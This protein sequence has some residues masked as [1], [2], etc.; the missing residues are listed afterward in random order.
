MKRK[1]LK[2]E[3]FDPIITTQARRTSDTD[4][5]EVIEDFVKDRETSIGFLV[6]ENKNYLILAY[7][8]SETNIKDFITLPKGCILSCRTI[9][10]K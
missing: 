5:E 8:H 1:L 3:W 2:V 7:Q 10:Y 9:S 6:Y 4:W